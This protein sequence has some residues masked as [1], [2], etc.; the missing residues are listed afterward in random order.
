MGAVGATRSIIQH[1]LHKPNAFHSDKYVLGNFIR[2]R[3]EIVSA[4]T[5]QIYFDSK[6]ML[7]MT[8]DL[9]MVCERL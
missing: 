7:L 3:D 6:V 5:E 8:Y 1:C 9:R 4:D 2:R